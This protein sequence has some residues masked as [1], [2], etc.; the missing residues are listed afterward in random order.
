MSDATDT[1]EALTSEH[2]LSDVFKLRAIALL[3]DRF[4]QQIE[5]LNDSEDEVNLLADTPFVGPDRRSN[6]ILL[7]KSERLTLEKAYAAADAQVSA[8]LGVSRIT[9]HL[10]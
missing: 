1:F 6:A 10:C 2:A 4:G 8:A 9:D 7:R 3:Q 5:R